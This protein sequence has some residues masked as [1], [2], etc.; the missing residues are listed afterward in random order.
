MFN[1][2]K[3]DMKM[4]ILVS[5]RWERQRNIFLNEGKHKVMACGMYYDVRDVN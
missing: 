3:G 4:E 1:K 2:R 5:V